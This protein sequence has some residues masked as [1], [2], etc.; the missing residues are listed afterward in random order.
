MAVRSTVFRSAVPRRPP[1]KNRMPLI[2]GCA[3]G[4]AAGAAVDSPG[5]RC[6][7]TPAQADRFPRPGCPLGVRIV[8]SRFRAGRR[9]PRFHTARA[10]GLDGAAGAGGRPVEHHPDQQVQPA[11]HFVLL[12]RP[13]AVPPRPPGDRPAVPPRPAGSGGQSRKR[14]PTGS[15]TAQPGS[16][17]CRRPGR[18]PR[19]S[20]LFVLAR[21]SPG[22]SVDGSSAVRRDTS[23][24]SRG[25]SRAAT[26]R[27]KPG[28]PRV[29]A[30]IPRSDPA[31]GKRCSR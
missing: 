5:H 8:V 16:R 24:S 3:G 27:R 17:Q 2:G 4:H 19:A 20:S 6:A 26:R 12:P 21:A 11:L 14:E 10:A 15:V 22:R 9:G 18:G 13:A 30:E 25:V 29:R 28:R 31:A 1:A 7:G 23:T